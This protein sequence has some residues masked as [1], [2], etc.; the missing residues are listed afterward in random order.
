[1]KRHRGGSRGREQ[2]QDADENPALLGVRGDTLAGVQNS[3]HQLT[4]RRAEP[5]ANNNADAAPVRWLTN[6]NPSPRVKLR[7]Q[8]PRTGEQHVRLIDRVDSV[9]TD[10]TGGLGHVHRVLA[11]GRGLTRQHRLRAH[12]V[13]L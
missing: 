5:G 8:Y 9:K 1:M 13:A 10:F 3:A 7:S 2:Q 6:L 4:L 12:R 11:L